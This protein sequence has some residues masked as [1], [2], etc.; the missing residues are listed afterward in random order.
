M[1]INKYIKFDEI[2]TDEVCINEAIGYLDPEDENEAK[3]ISV[4]S[5]FLQDKSVELDLDECYLDTD[6]NLLHF[7]FGEQGGQ[8]ESDTEGWSRDYSFIVDEDFLIVGASY[9]Q[10]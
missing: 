3:I 2:W 10:G 1:N 5:D 7:F 4:I 9:S 8:N 6:D